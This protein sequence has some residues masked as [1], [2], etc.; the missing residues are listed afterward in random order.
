MSLHKQAVVLT[1]ADLCEDVNILWGFF[2]FI[3]T[4]CEFTLGPFVLLHEIAPHP[5]ESL[6]HVMSIVRWDSVIKSVKNDTAFTEAINQ[7]IASLSAPCTVLRASE[8]L[9]SKWSSTLVA[10]VN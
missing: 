4:A 6:R 5:N 8:W 1:L 2:F 9:M 7:Q 3:A 10:A